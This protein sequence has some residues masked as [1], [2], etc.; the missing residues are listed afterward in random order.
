M[1][2]DNYIIFEN[3]R[4]SFDG[5]IISGVNASIDGTTATIAWQTNVI[6]DGFVEYDTDSGF[7]ASKEQGSSVKNATSHS[8]DVSGLEANTT[9]YYRVRSQRVNGGVTTDSIIN[10]FIS[11]DA[12]GGGTTVTSGGGGGILI[13]DKTDKLPPE[14]INVV[15]EDIESDK[16]RITWETDEE[17]TSFIEYGFNSEYGSVYGLWSTSTEHEVSIENLNDNTTYHFRALSSDDW[18]NIGYSEDLA[19]N[20]GTKEPVIVEPGEEP[21]PEPQPEEGLEPQPTDE[22]T[23]F[24]EAT[25]R[26]M[27]FLGRLFPEI[28]INNLSPEDLDKINTFEELSTFLPTPI[29]SGEPNVVVGTTEATVYWSTDVDSNSLVAIAP[30][31]RY[32]PGAEESY[33]QV[34]GDVEN[35]TTNHEVKV[36]GLTP[37]TQYHFQVRSKPSVGAAA[38][39]RD[40][41]FKTNAEELVISS[42][43]AQVIDNETVVFKWVT[44]KDAN[45][46]VRLAPYRGNVLAIDQLKVIRDNVVSVIHEVTITDF[47]AGTFYD[48]ELSSTDNLG[49][50]ATQ[51]LP[52]FSTSEDDLPPIV[53]HIKADSTVFIDR[54]NKI[55]TIVSWLTNEPATSR[56]YFQEGVQGGNMELSEATELNADYSKEHVMII[57]QFQPGKVYSFRVESIDSGSNITTSK[58]HTFMTA[59]KKESIIDIIIRILE[60]TFSWI[61][62]LK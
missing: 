49:N 31:D 38:R 43:F 50:V 35:L 34:I 52:Y 22:E 41:V 44:N 5:P 17:S 13:I 3:V 32:N 45:S 37:N 62:K 23:I 56:V 57:N 8:V 11:G 36:Y 10:T 18:G 16:A 60:D 25:R 54:G 1:A 58:V 30:E 28:S 40:F 2:S 59:K 61:K 6:S 14:I 24:A 27:E 51:V 47:E 55:Q 4:Y 46:T 19:F 39:S 9:Y 7:S 48:I 53:S 26:T 42:Y 33:S 29:L 12:E 20:T 21:E 15:I